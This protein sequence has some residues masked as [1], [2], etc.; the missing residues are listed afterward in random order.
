MTFDSIGGLVV[1]SV[2]DNKCG[3]NDTRRSDF[4]VF[5]PLPD[6]LTCAWRPFF[7]YHTQT[8]S[9]HYPLLLC[10]ESEGDR[11]QEKKKGREREK[12][13]GRGG[14]GGGY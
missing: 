1:V 2:F 5:F 9:F 12:E 10:A 11:E 3:P 8:V 4:F 7:A 13:G 6:L 14:A